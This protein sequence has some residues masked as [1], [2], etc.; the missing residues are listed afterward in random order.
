MRK[1]QT[2]DMKISFVCSGGCWCASTLELMESRILQFGILYK[3]VFRPASAAVSATGLRKI[4]FHAPKHAAF[5]IQRYGSSYNFFG[6]NLES[7]LKSTVKAPTKQTSQRHDHL[8]KELACRQHKHFVCNE[9]CIN[10]SQSR[11]QFRKQVETEKKMRR[12]SRGLDQDETQSVTTDRLVDWE[13]HMPMFHLTQEGDEEWSTHVGS[14]HTHLHKVVYPN[15]VSKDKTDIFEDG[16]EE[17]VLKL[18]DCSGDQGFQRIECSCDGSI[19]STQGNQRDILHC[20]PSFHSYPYLKRSWHDWAMVKW[21][22]QNGDKVEY[23]YFAARLLLFAHLSNNEDEFKPPRKVVAVIHSLTEYHP[24]RDPLLFFAKGDT[25]DDGGI[26]VVEAATIEG[27]AFVLPCVKQQ[28]DIFPTSH[29]TAGSLL[30]SL[31]GH[32]GQTFGRTAKVFNL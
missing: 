14:I 23:V 3:K 26:D 13:L 16:E 8:L 1:F 10:N 5:Y 4:K 9:S 32:S 25:L 22:Y 15:F 7:A 24:P 31:H 2:A 28:G 18:A 6:G 19:P 30:C 29:E 27:T 17:Y 11:E 12:R 21:L 20:H